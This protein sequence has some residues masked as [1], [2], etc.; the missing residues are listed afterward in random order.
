MLTKMLAIVVF[1]N[2]VGFDG[3]SDELIEH[4]FVVQY[5]NE[6]YGPTVWVNAWTLSDLDDDDFLIWVQDIVEPFGGAVM[7]AGPW[8]DAGAVPRLPTNGSLQPI[9][10][11]RLP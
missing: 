9:P 10:I 1:R 5:L 3:G 4:G 6:I 7:V 11:N 2:A 8:H